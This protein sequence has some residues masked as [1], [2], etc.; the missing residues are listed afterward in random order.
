[1]KG[2]I[3]IAACLGVSLISACSTRPTTEPVD[4]LFKSIDKSGGEITS[5]G[6]KVESYL[7][8]IR[9]AIQLHMFEPERFS[10]KTCDFKITLDRSGKVTSITAVDGYPPL[11]EA[12]VRAIKAADIPAPPDDET[13]QVFKSSIIEFKPQ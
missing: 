1:M 13:Y 12:G 6:S 4:N 9:Q 11:C 5:S 7:S 3:I 10:R 2:R 8:L